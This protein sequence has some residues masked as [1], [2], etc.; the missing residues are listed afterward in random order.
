MSS[1]VVF[2][3]S[4]V[5][6]ALVFPGG[7]LEWLRRHWRGSDCVPLISSKTALELTRVLTYEKFHLALA[8]QREL[9]GDYLPW[10]EVTE[11]SVSCP[12]ICRDSKDQPFLDLAHCGKAQVLISSDLDL[13][14]LAGRT[15]F[16]IESPESYRRR[17]ASQ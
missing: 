3:T 12:E 2:D 8:D 5:V 14:A 13:L 1:R 7:R 16:S 11:V 6:S 17:V 15:S 4:T 9:L 10:C